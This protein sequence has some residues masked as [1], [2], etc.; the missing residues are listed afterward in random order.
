MEYGFKIVIE[1]KQLF[2]TQGKFS[3]DR[4]ILF[5]VDSGSWGGTNDFSFRQRADVY[6]AMAPS[7]PIFNR[8]IFFQKSL[9]V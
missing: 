7:A 9:C 2:Q 1:V 4:E 5:I 8:C 6:G 3:C